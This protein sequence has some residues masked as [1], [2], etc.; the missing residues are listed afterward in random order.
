MLVF[1]W[2]ITVPVRTMCKSR[3]DI[4]ILERKRISE[5]RVHD[6]H[7]VAMATKWS[8]PQILEIPL[9]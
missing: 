5:R 8:K 1:P 4:N 2:K 6:R 9:S 3:T 7:K